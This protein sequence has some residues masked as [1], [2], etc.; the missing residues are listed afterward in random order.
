MGAS[1]SSHSREKEV[2]AS[3]ASALHGA[4]MNSAWWGII[5][6]YGKPKSV[7]THIRIVISGLSE[8]YHSPSCL[9]QGAR[10]L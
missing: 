10:V 3:V 8:V 6:T 2:S 5:A 1:S 4:Q 9:D 7:D